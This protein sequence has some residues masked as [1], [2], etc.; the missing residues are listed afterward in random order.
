MQENSITYPILIP[1][2]DGEIVEETADYLI[3]F[4]KQDKIFFG[5]YIGHLSRKT[6]IRQIS[7]NPEKTKNVR[8]IKKTAWTLGECEWCTA[9]PGLKPLRLPRAPR[10]E[11]LVLHARIRAV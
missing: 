5:F 2:K 8:R 1:P 6:I 10:D 3:F 4:P 7:K 11:G 9:A